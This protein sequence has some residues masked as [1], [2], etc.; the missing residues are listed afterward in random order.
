MDYLESVALLILPKI[1]DP[2]HA[3]QE[4]LNDDFLDI[5]AQ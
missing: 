4:D 1:D 2:P 5:L 3:S